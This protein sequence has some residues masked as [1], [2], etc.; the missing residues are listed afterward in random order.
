M[1][2][3]YLEFRVSKEFRWSKEIAFPEGK[4]KAEVS[5]SMKK[6]SDNEEFQYDL[7]PDYRIRRYSGEYVMTVNFEDFEQ[8]RD[9]EEV[10]VTN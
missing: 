4:Y 6:V 9:R 10:T 5:G 3:T 1:Y 7:P 2:D 8:L